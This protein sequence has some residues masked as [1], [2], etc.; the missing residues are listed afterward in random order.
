[1][2]YAQGQVLKVLDHVGPEIKWFLLGGPADGDEAQVLKAHHPDLEVIGFEPNYEMRKLQARRGFPGE[3]VPCALWSHECELELR[4]MGYG[5]QSERSGSVV[6]W[7]DKPIDTHAGQEKLE[8]PPYRAAYKVPARPLDLLSENYGPFE[9]AFLWVDVEGAELAALQG[10]ARLLREGKIR[11]VSAEAFSDQEAAIKD[12]LA[13][14]G[15][16]EALRWQH[17]VKDDKEWSDILF[18]RVGL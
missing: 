17:Q 7:R 10:A 15:L 5:E 2:I 1:M 3:L 6:K 4:L 9:D 12:F 11:M 18:K 8:M 16:V 13:E 14:F